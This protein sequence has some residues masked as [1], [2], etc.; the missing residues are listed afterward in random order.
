M[1]H[2]FTK[3]EIDKRF[4]D[5]KGKTLGEIDIAGD[6]ERTLHNPK[7]TGIAGDV[8][9]HSILGY[10]S[11]T[12]Q[13]PDIKI[14][15]V[16]IEVKTTGV[17]GDYTKPKTLVA[18]ERITI[19]NVSP[20]RI[21]NETFEDST[22][23]DKLSRTLLAFYL[24]DSKTVV[25]ASEYANFRFLGYELHAVS[26][27]D[28]KIIK[29]DWEIVRNF[30]A[31]Q[32]VIDK[33]DEA[34]AA[35]YSAAK[36][37]M[38]YLETAPGWKNGPRFAIKK[39]YANQ[40]IQEYFG[41]QA[42]AMSS[43][44][45]SYAELD[46]FLARQSDKYKGMTLREIFASLNLDEKKAKPKQAAHLLMA[47]ILNGNSK[48]VESDSQFDLVK[49]SGLVTKIFVLDQKGNKKED[50]KFNYRIDFD[51]FDNSDKDVHDT[52]VYDYF[53]NTHFLF[54]IFQNHGDK[55]IIE[56]TF[57]GFKRLTFS[58]EYL[59]ENLVPVLSRLKELVAGQEFRVWDKVNKFGNVV[60]NSNGLPRTENNFPKS[61]EHPFFLRGSGS[62]SSNK[63][64]K[65]NGYN[66]Y[67]MQMW[68]HGNKL[69]ELLN[70][71]NFLQ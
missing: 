50:C 17:R 30:C 46:A 69:L 55:G 68:L 57:L 51:E 66:C 42:A 13:A 54:A 7:I 33:K 22:L 52:D 8:V 6:F 71:Q 27:A 47:K 29:N 5:A 53:S 61:T 56:N 2:V 49:K 38:M 31:S 26:E 35:A 11:D 19:T 67:Q 43:A 10:A 24:Y 20:N 9:E 15:G 60:Y 58:D 37:E 32:S 48:N 70:E 3:Q 28:R 34:Q 12:K 64:L 63:P 36:K 45:S 65:I 14:D 40:I 18:K 39:T 62:N 23:W 16:D 1:E 59:E 4:N 41:K 44:V 25:P 21:K